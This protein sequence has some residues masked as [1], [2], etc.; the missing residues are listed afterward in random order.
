MKAFF[1]RVLCADNNP[2]FRHFVGWFLTDVGCEV[3]AVATASEALSLIRQRPDGYDLLIVANWLPDMDGLQLL[4]TVNSMGYAGR[5]VITAPHLS[6]EQ[7]AAYES[8]RA[9]SILITPIG[10]SE[11]MRILEP[12]PRVRSAEHQINEKGAT[13]S[14]SSRDCSAP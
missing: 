12:G 2:Y 14:H 13:S 10:Y 7:R 5:I 1:Q 6:L 4:Q 3:A 8:L 9:S 11:L